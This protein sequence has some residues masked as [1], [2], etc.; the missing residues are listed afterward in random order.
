MEPTLNF[1]CY[2]NRPDDDACALRMIRSV[3]ATMP[4]LQ[5]I[6]RTDEHSKPVK[7]VDDV[8]RLAY[9]DDDLFCSYWIKHVLMMGDDPV[10]IADADIIYTRDVRH[11][12]AR[13]FSVALTVREDGETL[14]P[15]QH[16]CGGFIL[17]RCWHFWRD[18]ADYIRLCPPPLRQWYAG[19]VAL[20]HIAPRFPGVMELPAW[21]FNHAPHMPGEVSDASVLHFKG[22]QRKQWMIDNYQP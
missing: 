19:Q 13:D 7:G 14:K 11:L 17:S 6:Q 4:G 9:A 18:V 10:I 1:I 5:I 15:V 12:F 16:Y 3:R 21:Q 2:G 22:P 20:H 8:K